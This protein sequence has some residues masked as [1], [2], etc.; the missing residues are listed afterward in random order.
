MTSADI[1]NLLKDLG[2][3]GKEILAVMPTEEAAV[4][5]EEDSK[6]LYVDWKCRGCGHA[7]TTKTT[8]GMVARR[9]RRC[10]TWME[11]RYC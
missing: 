10:G 11:W 6:H 8:E 3:I 5:R 1:E 2:V 7:A 9:C 4:K